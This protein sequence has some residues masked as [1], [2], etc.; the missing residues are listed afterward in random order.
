MQPKKVAGHR[1]EDQRS[2]DKAI[3]AN[4]KKSDPFL[5]SYLGSTFSLRKGDKPHAM[6]F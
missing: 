4:I 1:A 2:V 3:L 5:L 6:V